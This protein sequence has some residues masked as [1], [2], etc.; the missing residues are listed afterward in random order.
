MANGIHTLVQPPEPAR[1][2]PLRNP[3]IAE[4]DI[5]Q[6]C[7]RNHAPLPLGKPSQEG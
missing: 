2:Y 5:A 1:L 7:P 4:P 6:L 3:A